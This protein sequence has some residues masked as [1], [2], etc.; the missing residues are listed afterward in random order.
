[1]RRLL[2]ISASWSLLLSAPA[3]SAQDVGSGWSVEGEIGVVTDYRFR[4]ASLSG[5]DPAVQGGVTAW[6]AGS[7]LYGFVWVST[8]EEYG[9]DASGNGAEIEVTLGVGWSGEALGYVFDIGVEAYQYPRGQG[10]NYVEFPLSA[11]RAVGPV[12]LSAGLAWAPEQNA[13]GNEDNTYVWTG[14]DYAPDG[15]PLSLNARL[16]H[17]DGSVAPDGKTDWSV[18]LKA[19]VSRLTLGLDWIDS[20]AD[21]G[22]VVASVFA[23]F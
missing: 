9:L 21:D 8:I 19:P 16:G 20:D 22:T 5:T 12:T 23:T 14:V 7:G 10:V 18:G 13:L 11:E 2:L 15:W 3:A 4:G 17:E 6:N 1:M